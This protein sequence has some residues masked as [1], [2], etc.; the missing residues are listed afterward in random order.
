MTW[1]YYIRQKFYAVEAFQQFLAGVH[2]N[3]T[4]SAV[5]IVGSDGGEEFEG[6]LAEF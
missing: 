3:G 2:A 4:S 6:D 5:E 1:I